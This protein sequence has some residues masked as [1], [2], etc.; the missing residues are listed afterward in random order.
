MADRPAVPCSS[1]STP[2]LFGPQPTLLT[3][4]EV[5][6]VFCDRLAIHRSTFYES[7]RDA[8]PVLHTRRVKVKGARNRWKPGSPRVRK[9]VAYKLAELAASGL[10]GQYLDGAYRDAHPELYGATVPSFLNLA[11]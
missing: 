3:L 1:T 4:S 8:L 6:V 5:E 11:A 2:D 10:W 7:F 9:D